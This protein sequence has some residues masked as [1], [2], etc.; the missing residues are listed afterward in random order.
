MPSKRKTNKGIAAIV[1]AAGL[2]KRFGGG[3]GKTLH[4]LSGR[5]IIVRTLEAFEQ[6]ELVDKIVLVFREEELVSASRLIMR[7]GFTKVLKVVAGGRQRQ[8]SVYN[9]LR[10][11]DGHAT[12]VVVHDGARPLIDV[13]IINASIK[14]LKNCDGVIAA[15]PVKDTIKEATS[16]RVSGGVYVRT[17]P[18]RGLLWAVQTPQ[19]FRLNRLLEVHE[20][21]AAEGYYSTDDAA[22]IERY[23]G[24][25]RIIMGSYRNIKITTPEDITVAKVLLKAM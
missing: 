13:S 19:T 17:T 20:K 8:D 16:G 4:I 2:G 21:A 3:K 18:E 12:V 1:P 22:L 14:A 6:C 9:G 15:V 7:Y 23:G 24:K 10:A 25:V 5:P 11:L